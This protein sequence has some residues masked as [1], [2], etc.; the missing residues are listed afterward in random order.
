[1]LTMSELRVVNDLNNMNPYLYDGTG[2]VQLHSPMLM[3]GIPMGEES[4]TDSFDEPSDS[5]EEWDKTKCGDWS[6]CP[7]LPLGEG[8]TWAEAT[9]ESWRKVILEKDAPTWEE[10]ICNSPQKNTE[11]EDSDWDEDTHAY[12]WSSQFEDVVAVAETCMDTVEESTAE[13]PPLENIVEASVGPGKPG[14]G[15]NPCRE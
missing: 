15:S 1:M 2:L 9:A 7:A 6:C 3:Q 13:L 8:P 5:G 11:K 12:L 14:H 10:V 4:D